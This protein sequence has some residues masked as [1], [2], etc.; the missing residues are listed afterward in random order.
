MSDTFGPTLPLPLMRYDLESSCWRT[1]EVT[2]LWALE[3]SCPIFP[4]WGMTLGGELFALP[5]SERPTVVPGFS[6]LLTTPCVADGKNSYGR[7]HR[8][9]SR[10]AESSRFDLTDQ[11]AAL[12]PTPYAGL[13]ERGRDGVYPN[14]LGQQDLQHALSALLPTPTA[15]AAKHAETPDTNAHAFGSNLWD[16][17]TLLTTGPQPT[18]TDTSTPKWNGGNTDPPSDAGSTS[19]DDTHQTQLFPA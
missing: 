4:E 7:P 17:P 11:V 1:S 12:L 6:L 19:S 3:M 8:Y 13:G 14:P 18:A 16:L 9:D 2:S 15:Q 10:H 5:T